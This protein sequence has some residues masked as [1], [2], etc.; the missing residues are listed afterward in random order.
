MHTKMVNWY[1][2]ILCGFPAPA[3]A[4]SKILLNF[5]ENM[6]GHFG[7]IQKSKLQARFSDDPPLPWE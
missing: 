1:L 5:L 2:Q 6:P 3:I 4:D 7:D